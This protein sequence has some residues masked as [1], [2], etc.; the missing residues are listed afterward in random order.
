MTVHEIID[1]MIDVR[2]VPPEK[3]E[4][5]EYEAA[6]KQ[7]HDELSTIRDVEAACYHEAGHWAYAVVAANQFGVDGS[8]FQVVGPRIRYDASDKN[9]PYDATPTALRLV[10][11]QNWKPRS[12]DDVEIMARV[13]VAG[14]ESVHHFYGLTQKR[15]DENDNAR[16]K[17]FCKEARN[18]LGG[19]I[20]APHVY[21]GD[22]KIEVRKNF[23][24]VRSVV[25]TKAKE[26]MKEQ[27]G[28]V[29]VLRTT[30]TP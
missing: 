16:F 14:G 6:R 7:I 12:D 20:D 9:Y 22:A 25:E 4:G 29:F 19:L 10:G 11:M 24:K 17:I 30:E 3:R 1:G 15:G 23:K 26:I 13:A 27:F 28:P 21:W 5:S 18:R 8:L 2:D